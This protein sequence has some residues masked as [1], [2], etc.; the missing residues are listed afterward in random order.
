M[1]KVSLKLLLESYRPQ[2]ADDPLF[3]EALREVAADPELAAWFADMQRFDAVIS[4]KIQDVPV[5]SD[6]KDHILLGYRVAPSIIPFP[7]PRLPAALA[8]IAAMLVLGLF[9]WHW[10]AP[11]PRPMNLLAQQAISFSDKMPPLQFVC[12]NASSV[13]NWI[14]RQP[15][16]QQVGLQLPPPPAS[17]GMGMIGS[18]VVNW[19]GHP[20]VMICLQNGKQ[21]AMLYVLK[22]SDIADLQEGTTETVQKADWVVRASSSHGQVRL[23]ATKGRP[24]DLNFPMP[25]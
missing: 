11:A 20:V 8:A 14:N 3:A 1:D 4:A 10:L 5:P 19:N 23:L 18:S 25:F 2:D 16:A 7:R 21:M 24:E 6:L 15:G 13:A 12:F 9:S 22:A 17:M